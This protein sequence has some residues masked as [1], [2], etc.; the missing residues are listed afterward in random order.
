[1]KNTHI[2]SV[3]MEYDDKVIKHRIYEYSRMDWSQESSDNIL[4]ARTRWSR[5]YNI[6]TK[7]DL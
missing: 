4:W 2:T 1:M 5:G 6:W 7:Q 3:T